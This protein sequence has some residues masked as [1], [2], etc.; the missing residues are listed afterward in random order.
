MQY[1]LIEKI[2]PPELLVGR[3]EEFRQFNKWLDK[4]PDKVSKSRVIMARRKSGK[5]VFVQRIFNQL[6]NE[7]GMTVP[8]FYDVAETNI[9]YP[10]LAID[11]YRA[12][13]SQYISFLER[14]EK[15]V[16][17]P[18]SIEG[19][20]KYGLTNAIQPFVRDVDFLLQNRGAGG[21]H[22]LMWDTAC[23]APHRFA[24]FY[25]KRFLVIIDEFQY[26]AQYVYP[27]QFCQT[28]PI[29][30]LPGSF[31]SLS[32]SKIAPMLV[33]GSYIGWLLTIIHK[34]FEGGRLTQMHFPPYLT[35][36]EGLEAVYTYARLY[37]EPITNETAVQINELCMSDPFFISCVVQYE[38]RD[39][40]LTTSTEIVER[41]NYE[42]S[43]RRSD[44]SQTWNEYILRAWK[45]INDVYA[46]KMLLH[47]SKHADRYWVPSE[48]KDALSLPLEISQ[49]QKKLLLLSEADMIEQGVADIDFR[50]LQ[51][52]TLNLILRNR[53]EEEIK[54]SR[55]PPDLKGE[56]EKK[57]ETLTAKN[58]QL[59]EQLNHLSGKMAE[60][61]LAV[62]FRSRKCF[63]LSDFFQDAADTARLDIIEVK[64]GVFLQR[65]DGKKMEIDVVA[66]SSCGRTVLVEVKKTQAKTGVAIIENF[67]EKATA[68]RKQFPEQNIL[69]AFLS[70]GGFTAEARQKCQAHGIGRAEKILHY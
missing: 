19:I 35:K 26:L 10:N 1:P 61:L 67:Q 18:L 68:Y 38:Q 25:D 60:H 8:F 15:L 31:H 7:N 64:E 9:W 30:S 34:H 14:D 42:M 32:E 59:Q 66:Q 6:W 65:S 16:N 48:I 47:L 22:Y 58:L 17:S 54:E 62:A 39:Q 3:E 52:G 5:T 27:D 36:E 13:A 41:V 23:S 69:P 33:T 45:H 37:Q 43:N 46:K 44:M 50:G 56:F 21:S 29:E 55:Q 4:I 24:D 49:I 11:Y 2:G 57:I 28:A 40:D 51:D 53:F 20:R 70:L 12:F 63:A